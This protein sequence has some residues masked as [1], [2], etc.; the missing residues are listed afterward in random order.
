MPDCSGNFMAGSPALTP[1]KLST[2][3][4]QLPEAIRR[5]SPG[6]PVSR[7][8]ITQQRITIM[9]S[10]GL[11]AGYT[12]LLHHTAETLSCCIRAGRKASEVVDV[13]DLGTAFVRSDMAT[14]KLS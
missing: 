12:Q 14:A 1:S 8:Q 11:H 13:E 5:Q 3:M 9:L 10:G 6:A 4:C 2:G 7:Q